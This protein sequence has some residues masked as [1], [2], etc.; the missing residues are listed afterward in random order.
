MTMIDAAIQR[1]RTRREQRAKCLAVAAELKRV[2]RRD[3]VFLSVQHRL[4]VPSSSLALDRLYDD[5]EE[6]SLR[7]DERLAIKTSA[8]SPALTEAAVY[9]WDIY[10]RFAPVSTG[11]DASFAMW[12]AGV[13]ASSDD[14]TFEAHVSEDGEQLHVFAA[15]LDPVDFGRV[16][17]LWQGRAHVEAFVP[18]GTYGEADEALEPYAASTGRPAPFEVSA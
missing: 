17:R 9:A 3:H 18:G 6:L 4:T 10:G 15:G 14:L 5:L 7:A 16:E 11:M 13:E 1:G 12:L 8:G 2:T